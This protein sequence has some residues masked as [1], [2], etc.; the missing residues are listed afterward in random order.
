MSFQRFRDAAVMVLML[1]LLGRDSHAHS[2]SDVVTATEGRPYAPLDVSHEHQD[3]YRTLSKEERDDLLGEFRGLVHMGME[4]ASYE[5][6]SG[7]SMSDCEPARVQAKS[8]P[9][10]D[11]WQYKCEIITGE[12]NGFYYFYPNALRQTSTLQRVDVRLHTSDHSLL[13]DLRQSLQSLFGR[14]SS[15]DGKYHWET[16]EEIAELSIDSPQDDPQRLIRFTWNRT[17]PAGTRQA[18][19]R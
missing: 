14:S 17:P 18:L 1:G 6:W 9:W 3:P 13:N 8:V 5:R 12:G 11:R 10:E 7:K 19:A 16:G 15:V 2:A 4:K